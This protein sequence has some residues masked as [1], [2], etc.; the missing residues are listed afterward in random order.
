MIQI[1]ELAGNHLENLVEV[2][3]EAVEEE[4][5][6]QKLG[7]QSPERTEP[8]QVKREYCISTPGWSC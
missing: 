4:E 2:V 1:E 8:L 6:G 5:E 3:E 7:H